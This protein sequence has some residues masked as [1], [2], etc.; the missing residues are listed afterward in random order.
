MDKKGQSEYKGDGGSPSFSSMI[1]HC[2]SSKQNALEHLLNGALDAM[3]KSDVKHHL[4]VFFERYFE[5]AS[6]HVIVPAKSKC[7][8]ERLL[9][10][11]D[12]KT[13]DDMA[14]ILGNLMEE[15]AKQTPTP[16]PTA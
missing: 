11:M 5:L 8:K 4:G 14:R 2:E 15:L 12:G 16:D 6:E 7:Y 9:V 10:L 3:N 1:K 13:N